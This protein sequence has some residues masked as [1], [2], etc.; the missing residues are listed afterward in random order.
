MQLIGHS[1]QQAC[2][3]RP[4]KHSRCP[5]MDRRPPLLERLLTDIA[6]LPSPLIAH[7]AVHFLHQVSKA[8]QLCSSALLITMIMAEVMAGSHIR[9]MSQVHHTFL[10]ALA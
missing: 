6:E 1:I 4:S 8:D 10:C 5:G 9:Q 7:P 2:I 3:G